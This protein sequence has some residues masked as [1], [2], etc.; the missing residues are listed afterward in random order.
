MDYIYLRKI[1]HWLLLVVTVLV[2]ASGFGIT[3]YE[4]VGKLTFGFL[5]KASSLSLH[6][7]LAVPFVIL[8]LA[9]LM[10]VWGV[11]RRR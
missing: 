5:D 2:I 8:L 10:I 1:L 4:I 9:H 6:S 11:G 7:K 3:R